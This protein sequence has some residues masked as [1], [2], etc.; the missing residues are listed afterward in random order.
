MP[1]VV[2]RRTGE[3]ISKTE[4]TQQQVDLLWEVIVRSWAKKHPEIFRTMNSAEKD[5]ED[6]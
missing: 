4:L 2:D 6:V 3:T 5:T 1:I